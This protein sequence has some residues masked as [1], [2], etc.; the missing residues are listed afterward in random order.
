MKKNPE[1]VQT[2]VEFHN[3]QARFIQSRVS[4]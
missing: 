3:K 4:T 2:C 1:K